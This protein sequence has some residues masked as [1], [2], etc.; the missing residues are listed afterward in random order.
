MIYT[1]FEMT[2]HEYVTYHLVCAVLTC[3]HDH[4]CHPGCNLFLLEETVVNIG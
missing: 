3:F 4:M 1:T 2:S